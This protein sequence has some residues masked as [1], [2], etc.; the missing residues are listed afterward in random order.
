MK[1]LLKEAHSVEETYALGEAIGLNACRNMVFLLDGDLGA[2]KTTLTQGIA[3]GLGVK[4]NVTSPTFTIHKVYKGRLTLNHIDA[5]RL[6]GIQQD[7]GFDELLQDGGVTVVEWPSFMPGLAP[8]EYM[9][10]SLRLLDGESR[11]FHLKAHGGQYERM[12]EVLA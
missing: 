4:R 10:I 9:G 11:L 2:G 1:E 7:L 5:Y 12:L 8:E 6:E 3:K